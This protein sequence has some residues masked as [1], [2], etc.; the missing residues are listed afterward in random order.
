MARELGRPAGPWDA[1]ERPGALSASRTLLVVDRH[2]AAFAE[3]LQDR[4]LPTTFA[5]T[6]GAAV[7]WL[8]LQ[9]PAVVLLDLEMERAGFLMQLFRAEGRTV[10]A[11]SDDTAA[12]T[13]ALEAGCL[14][15]IPASIPIQELSLK[16][17]KVVQERRARRMG[18]IAAPPLLVDLSAKRLLWHGEAVSA[19]GVLV[20]FAACLASRPG[21]IVPTRVILGDVW[22]EP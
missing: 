2:P 14:D 11:M 18:T 21:Q 8:R 10:L 17:A 1:R 9:P 6:A 12:R 4:G 3:A 16:I 13:R 5:K 15:A 19:S 22:G 20:Y 7:Y